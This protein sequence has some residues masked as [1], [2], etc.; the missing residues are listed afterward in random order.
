M[1]D[2]KSLKPIFI[3]LAEWVEDE[4][5]YGNFSEGDQIPSINQFASS[6][7]VNPATA[8]K[9]ISRLVEE[10]IIYKKR[11]IGMFVKE[12]AKARIQEK[13]KEHFVEEYV[14]VLV[15]EARKLGIEMKELIDMIEKNS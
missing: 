10:E 7:Q 9:G 11:G 1:F 8:N 15:E 12:G 6:F 5:I 3:Q 14:L 2:E 13:R 4:I